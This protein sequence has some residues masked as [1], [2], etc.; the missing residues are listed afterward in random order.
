MFP[1][2]LSIRRQILAGVIALTS[3]AAPFAATAAETAQAGTSQPNATEERLHESS[4]RQTD[5]QIARARPS[6]REVAQRI[7]DKRATWS[8]DQWDEYARSMRGM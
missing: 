7:R 1:T 3:F 4:G 8:Q 5:L 6:Q 2:S